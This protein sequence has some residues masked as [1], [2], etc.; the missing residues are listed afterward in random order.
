MRARLAAPLAQEAL[1]VAPPLLCVVVAAVLRLAGPG[2]RRLVLAPAARPFAHALPALLELDDPVDGPVEELAVVR[3]DHDAAAHALDEA[4]E[5]R[6][7][8]EVEVV[9]RLVEAVDVMAR[10][11]ERREPGAR[12]LA[13]GRHV[14][15]PLGVEAQLGCG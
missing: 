11:Q 10:E 4:L 12:G 7:P 3:D 6:E 2:A 8:V 13:A 1:D 5:P 14:E 9:R 15:R